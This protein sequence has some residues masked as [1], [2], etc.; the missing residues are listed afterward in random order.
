MKLMGL[1]NE[2]ELK[3]N[4][5]DADHMHA[6][7]SDPSIRSMLMNMVQGQE[8]NRAQAALL[9]FINGMQM[10]S[11]TEIN[12]ALQASFMLPGEKL[13]LKQDVYMQAKGKKDKNGDIDSDICRILFVL[14]L[15]KMNE[16]M[17]DMQI[18]KRIMSG[19][20]YN[21]QKE[22]SMTKL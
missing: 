15:E 3:L 7:K 21:E 16:T 1:N 20:I 2:N 19:N 10:Q 14:E 11:I 18:Q 8:G 12:N 22:P 5:D 13:S 4:L 9:H 6:L 17:I